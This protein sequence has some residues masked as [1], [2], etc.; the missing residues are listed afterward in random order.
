MGDWHEV[1]TLSSR[2]VCHGLLGQVARQVTFHS[3]LTDEQATIRKIVLLTW[4]KNVQYDL[5]RESASKIGE[6]LIW[7][8]SWNRPYLLVPILVCVFDWNYLVME[9][10]WG[11]LW[12]SH[13]LLLRCFTLY[14]HI[15]VTKGSLTCKQW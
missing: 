7:R 13:S 8:A 9:P 12:F 3:Q 11:V 2:K 6:L 15:P 10:H 1:L 14:F 4:W 5:P